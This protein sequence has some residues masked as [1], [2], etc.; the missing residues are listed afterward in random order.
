MRS[1]SF[2]IADAAIAEGFY[3]D[4][5]SSDQ[6]KRHVGSDPQHD[7]PRTMSKFIAAGMPETEVFARAT[8]RPA[9]LLGLTGEVGTL[10]AGACADIALLRWNEDGRLKDVQDIERS[11]GCWEPVVH[12]SCRQNRYLIREPPRRITA[13]LADLRHVSGLTVPFFA[14]PLGG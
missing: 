7:L 4:T 8:L 5:V 3:P 14:T 10:A 9:E 12:R 1:F 2:P 6:Y 11:G 13:V